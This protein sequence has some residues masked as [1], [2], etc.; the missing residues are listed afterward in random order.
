MTTY[1]YRTYSN[2]NWYRY[3][4]ASGMRVATRPDVPRLGNR[5]MQV[6]DSPRRKPRSEREEGKNTNMAVRVAKGTCSVPRSGHRIP[7]PTPDVNVCVRICVRADG[8][9]SRRMHYI[10]YPRGQRLPRDVMQT[11]HTSVTVTA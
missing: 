9:V 11:T 5:P 2:L 8:L 6:S 10:R 4:A 7:R 1:R 3:S